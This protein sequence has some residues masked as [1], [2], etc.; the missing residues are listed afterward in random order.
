MRRYLRQ[1]ITYK[2][3]YNPHRNTVSGMLHTDAVTSVFQRYGITSRR[4]VFI[5]ESGKATISSLLKRYLCN[6]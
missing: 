3:K 1:I 6:A 5:F 2:I 4:G